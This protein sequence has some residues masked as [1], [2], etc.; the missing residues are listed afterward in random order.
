LPREGYQR[1]VKGKGIPATK[2]EPFDGYQ[3][4]GQTTWNG[5][6]KMPSIF[7]LITK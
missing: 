3:K 7:I 5:L 2:R 6:I 4:T 1:P